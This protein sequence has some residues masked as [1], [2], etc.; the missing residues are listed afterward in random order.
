M[1]T[2]R[3]PEFLSLGVQQALQMTL[4]ILLLVVLTI[5]GGMLWGE[6]LE[7]LGNLI[8]CHSKEQWKRLWLEGL[9]LFQ[10]LLHF[11]VYLLTRDDHQLIHQS[12]FECL[13]VNKEY[14]KMMEIIEGLC[15]HLM[16]TKKCLDFIYKSFFC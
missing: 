5:E 15:A 8:F 12:F 2:H 14:K 10:T 3:Y 16:F 6:M 13:I 7:L 11:W 4:R 9:L 1:E